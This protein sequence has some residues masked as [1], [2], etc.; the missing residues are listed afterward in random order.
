MLNKA[1]FQF[2]ILN[3]RRVVRPACALD[4]SQ[5]PQ[6]DGQGPTEAALAGNSKRAISKP[7][8]EI[9]VLGRI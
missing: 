1:K 8:S 9:P 5:G 2:A 3:A 7:F 4:T 6:L